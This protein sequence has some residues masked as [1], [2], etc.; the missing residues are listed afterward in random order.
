MPRPLFHQSWS[1][2]NILCLFKDAL[3]TFLLTVTLASKI[4]LLE[5]KTPK[6][7]NITTTNNNNNNNK[8]T[9]KKPT[10]NK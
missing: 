4:C 1:I 7:T 3:D 10:I 2:Y 8:Q 5:K 9:N 6:P